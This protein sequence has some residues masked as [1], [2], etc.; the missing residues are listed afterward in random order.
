MLFRSILHS[1]LTEEDGHIDP[2]VLVTQFRAA[3]LDFPGIAK[4]TLTH[5]AWC[6]YL[7]V[8]AIVSRSNIK[9]DDGR[10]STIGIHEV[11]N[12]WIN[13]KADAEYGLQSVGPQVKGCIPEATLNELNPIMKA[14]A[15]KLAAIATDPV[16]LMK[17][18][19]DKKRD[20][21]IPDG[22]VTEEN[23]DRTKKDWLK[24]L[25]AADPHGQLAGFK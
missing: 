7:G 13:R 5:S 10:F 11:E 3:S 19:A 8:D 18:Y 22:E 1:L 23:P 2:K 15:E 21:A 4:G 24:D 14:K 6:D 12:F 16:A 25:A 20:E 9:G 17:Y